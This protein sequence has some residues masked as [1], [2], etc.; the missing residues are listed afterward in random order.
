MSE[1]E[2][3]LA[4]RATPAVWVTA[5]TVGDVPVDLDRVFSSL[6][7]RHGR[8]DVDG[9]IQATTATLVLRRI[10]RGELPDFEVGL[11]LRIE[12]TFT[13][14]SGRPMFE[15]V[16]TDATLSDDDPDEPRLELIATG[17][18][19]IAGRRSVAGHAWPAE[20]WKARVERILAEAGL[21]G[22]VT[23][24]S[25]DVPIAATVPDDP[26]AGTFASMSAL[27]A[28]E[29][30]RQDVGAT[31]FDE[32]GQVVVQAFEG[33]RDL[34]PTLTVDPSLV[35]YSPPWSKTLDVANRIVLGYGYGAGTV[36]V[37]DPVSQ[38][39]FGIRWTGLF[40]S[41]LADQG[42]AQSRALEWLDRV[43][44]P[45]W[46]LPAVSLLEP[47]DLNIGQM[48]ELSRLPASAPYPSWSPVVEGWTDTVEGDLW[49]Q[50]V[51][52]SDPVLS[53]LAL[54][55]QDVTATLLW[56]DVD[57]ACLWRDAFLLSNLEGSA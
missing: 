7:V 9:P 42:T 15:G 4:E 48:I 31:A 8:D 2:L 14:A 17:P 39:R 13:A 38:A 34:F 56:Q 54:A 16:I 37:D 50:S 46:K 35:F 18:L 55:W 29:L 23:A 45:R 33:R 27:D 26:E 28:L 30:A 49:T 21:A 22:T 44:Y 1:L 40:D 51:V 3:E 57:P 19:A 32:A 25:P 53:G 12:S 24:A 36:S 5:I 10:T 6:S 11:E 20:P 43:A 47:L 41:G 52:V